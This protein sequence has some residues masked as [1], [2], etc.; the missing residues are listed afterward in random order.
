M[1]LNIAGMQIAAS[2]E[3]VVTL[4]AIFELLRL[5]GRGGAGLLGCRHFLRGGWAGQDAFS[6]AAVGGIV[7]ALPFAIWFFLAI[8]GVAMA[9]EEVRDPKRSIPRAYIGGIV[10]LVLLA[11]GVMVFA[12]GVGDWTQLANINDPL[13]QAMKR[14][15]GENS[16]WLHMLLWLGLFGLVASFH[17]IIIGY[18]RQMFALARAGYLPRVLARVHPRFHTPHV[19][20]LAGGAVGIAAIFSDGLFHIAGQ[21][22]TATI[23]TMSVF[24]AI[25]MYIVSH[26]EPVPS[27]ADVAGHGTAVPGPG[28]PWVPGFALVCAAICLVTMVYYNPQVALWFGAMMVA[29]LVTCLAVRG[30]GETTHVASRLRTVESMATHAHVIDGTRYVFDDLRTLLARATPARSGDRL[31]GVAA[32][33]ARERAAAQMALA[34]LPLQ[35]FPAR[36]G[37]PVRGRRGHAAHRGH[38]RRRRVR[39]DRPPDR[40]RIPRVAA[41]R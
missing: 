1:A 29:G 18:S 38:A 41:F 37:R 32:G 22:L 7:A 5:H 6:L 30:T 11:A 26:G 10:T 35:H 36:S 2:V 39:P 23:V 17:G 19:A 28:Y 40:R 13:P 3:L 25:V 14:V 4:V 12:G 31:A 27:P 16:G 15:V 34:D 20:I 8:E 33:S 21:T 9:A 24:G